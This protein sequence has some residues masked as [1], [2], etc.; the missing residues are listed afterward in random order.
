MNTKNIEEILLGVRQRSAPPEDHIASLAQD[1]KDNGLLHA[2]VLDSNGALVA[3]FCRLHAIKSLHKDGIPFLYDKHVIMSGEV[4]FITTHQVDEIGLFQVEL[5]ENLKRKNLSPV[6]EA[7]AVTKLHNLLKAKHGEAWDKKDTGEE[8][9]KLRGSE[10]RVEGAR[11][12]EVGNALLLNHFSK[13]PEVAQ[14]KTKK[15]ALRIAKS[16]SAIT[17]L[18][19]LGAATEVDKSSDFVILQGDCRLLMGDTP[20]ETYDGIVTDPPYGID[21][22]EFGEQSSAEGHV[23]DDSKEYS[24]ALARQIISE[25]FRI[26]RPNSHLYLFCDIRHWPEL[27]ARAK[28]VGWLPFATPIIWHKP[29]TGHAPQPGYFTRRYESILFARKGDRKLSSSHSDVFEHQGVRDKVYAA[30]KPVEL[31]KEILALSFFPGDVI[32]DPCAGSGSIY[33]A[34]KELK[35]K[36]VGMELEE[37]GVNLCKQVIGEL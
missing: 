8:L 11:A 4:P 37:K 28:E 25:G 36:V 29:G 19:A 21:A 23:Y 22:N 18:E 27:M 13:D 6:D 2:I 12:T 14:A 26:T 5:S 33:K 30:Q 1:I 15:E 24:I 17:L 9:E 10:A 34:A 20:N 35:M 3:G 31:L 16:K 7:A 32:L